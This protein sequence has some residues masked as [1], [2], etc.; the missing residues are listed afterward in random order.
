MDE[1][2]KDMS[3]G[4]S[5][6]NVIARVIDCV[7]E[8]PEVN[9]DYDVL[10][11]CGVEVIDGLSREPKDFAVVLHSKGFIAKQILQE[12]VELPV[13]S[14]EN[15][16]KLYTALLGV[17]EHYPHRY[18]EFVSILQDNTL[19]YGDLLK[20]LGENLSNNGECMKDIV[21]TSVY[22]SIHKQEWWVYL[23]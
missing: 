22:I 5:Q 23:Y 7:A 11:Q 2:S 17:V 8:S 21:Y 6:G 19:L 16:R 4:A 9:H 3:E 15:A 14:T 10:V 20:V 12:I 18:R 13:T 1:E